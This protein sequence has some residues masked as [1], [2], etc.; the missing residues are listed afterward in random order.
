MS[1]EWD[2]IVCLPIIDISND[3]NKNDISTEQDSIDFITYQ[4]LITYFFSIDLEPQSQMIR[5]EKKCNFFMKIL[6]YIIFWKNYELKP[7]LVAE[8]NRIIRIAGQSFDNRNKF[9]I[10]CLYTIFAKLTGNVI[11]ALK[12]FGQHWEEIGFQGSDPS[13]DFRG[14]GI[15][16][17]FQ[18]TFFVITPK[19][20]QL[21]KEIYDL[22]MDQVQHYPFA[23]T[24][25][26]ITQ[27]VLQMLRDG[28]LNCFINQSDSV[29]NIFNQ[30][31][32]GTF[33]HFHKIWK[34]DKKTIMD[35]GYVLK[36]VRNR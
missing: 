29:L 35:I 17:L 23:I 26:N 14:V 20:C 25:M 34:N 2:D 4:Q 5:L 31:Y 30:F 8:G 18:L 11:S 6:R 36:G 10:R 33:L 3:Y 21:S 16:G 24:S 7:H 28:S 12:R 22:S 9:H 15:L 1:E 13:T 27:I 19:V 32:Y